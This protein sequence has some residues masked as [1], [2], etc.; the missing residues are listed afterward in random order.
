MNCHRDEHLVNF[1]FSSQEAQEAIED[2]TST[3]S[4]SMAHRGET[5]A[6][7]EKEPRHTSMNMHMSTLTALTLGLVRRSCLFYCFTATIRL[8]VFW[9]LK[10]ILLKDINFYLVTARAMA[11]VFIDHDTVKTCT[12]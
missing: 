2:C 3:L 8:P 10:I 6:L 9:E 12:L 1:D 5:S 7:L 4:V 11:I